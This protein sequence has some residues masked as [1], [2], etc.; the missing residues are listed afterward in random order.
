MKDSIAAGAALALLAADDVV[1]Q[2]E[3]PGAVVARRGADTVDA[4]AARMKTI[5]M[6]VY[7]LMFLMI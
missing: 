3:A 7:R 1:V 2:R 5:N 4:C 6:K